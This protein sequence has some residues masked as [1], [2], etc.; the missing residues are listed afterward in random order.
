MK[1]KRKILFTQPWP[2]EYVT[3]FD[4]Y[5]KPLLDRGCEVVLDP[6]KTSLTEEQTI[7]RMPGLYAH[8]CGADTHT[9]KSLE[10]ADQLKIISRIGVGYD[11]VDVK[12][13][14]AKGVAV[15]ITPGASA[16]TVSEFAFALILTMTRNVKSFCGLEYGAG[17]PGHRFLGRH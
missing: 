15:T 1:M 6:I 16:E 11:S 7:E 10:Y 5:I 8:V 12:A 4:K 13:C 3:E 2:V 17:L 14:T 9:A